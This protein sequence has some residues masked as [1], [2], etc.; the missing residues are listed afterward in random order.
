MHLNVKYLDGDVDNPQIQFDIIDSGIGL[1][2]EQCER[3]FQPFTQANVD[4]NRDYGGTGLGL[5]ISRRLANLLGGDVS[6][7]D[8][9]PGKGSTFRVTV[10]TGPVKDKK[11]IIPNIDTHEMEEKHRRREKQGP[12]PPI[13]C[14]ALL[15]ED[16]MENQRLISLILNKA[17]VDVTVADNGK[18]AY[19]KA[20]EAQKN[21]TPFD[22]ILM[23][24]QMPVMDGYQA[25]ERLRNEK[26]TG[27][28]IA[29]TAHAMPGDQEKCLKCGCDNY[30]SKPICREELLDMV[31]ILAES[32][33]DETN[34]KAERY[35]SESEP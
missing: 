13:H 17:G 28:I 30:L 5:V 15:A 2:K 20:V 4:T 6:I 32:A 14:R 22:V 7:A 21:G 26:Y 31:Q 3:L 27:P 8:S 19:E 11:L 18:I 33:Q 29:M 16:Y 34:L 25:T 24:M 23:D 10:S 1:T 12:R 35:L 9:E